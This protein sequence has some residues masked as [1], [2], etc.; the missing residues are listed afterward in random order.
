M[1]MVKLPRVALGHWPTPLHELPHLSAALGG[2]RIFVKRD[3]L[4]GLALGGNKCRKLEYVLADALKNGVDTLI[5]SGSSQSNHALQTA[6]A[7][8]KL[9]MEAYLVLVKGMHVETQGN[10][11]L[12]NILNSTVNIVEVAD[13]SEMFTTMPRKMNELADEL[14]SKGRTPLVI[15][16]GAEF[17]LGTVGWVDA[18]EEIGRQLKDQEIDAQYVVLA[19]SGGGTQAGL[20]LGFKQL[21]LPLNVVGIST[22][23]Q[24]SAAVNEVVTLANDT[25]RLLGFDVTITPDEVTLY[26]DYIG[27]GYGIPTEG[28]IEAI[29]LVAQTEAIFL[30]PVYSA[31]AMAGF[32][33]LIRKGE[34]TSRDT[35]LFIHT[36]GVPALFAYHQELTG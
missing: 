23:Y 29:R 4:S 3:D 33:D 30:D 34:F 20:V 19:H 12:Q 28:C 27:E 36:G 11:L 6:A 14:R 17:P 13:P 5:T 26:D 32:V 15:P 10:L 16:A 1:S 18:A 35:V 24:K 8:R 2:P 22:M 21:K 7:A 31:K 9:G 25:A